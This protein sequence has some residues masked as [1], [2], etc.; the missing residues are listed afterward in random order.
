MANV[1][2][3]VVEVKYC[4]VSSVVLICCTLKE[5]SIA[6]LGVSFLIVILSEAAGALAKTTLL[7]VMV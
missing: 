2:V 6:V 1:D 4:V 3:A 7:P 5:V